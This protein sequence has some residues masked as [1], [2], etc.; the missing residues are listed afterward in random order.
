MPAVANQ[1]RILVAG[2]GNIFLGD[3]AFG[4]EVVR[5]LLEEPLPNGVEAVDFGIRG[6]DL[7]CAI[8]NG[9]D[10][11]VLVDA[12][13][14]GKPPGTLC[15]LEPDL[16]ALAAD[17]TDPVVEGHSLTP[18]SVLRWVKAL[19]GPLPHLRIVGC[20]PASIGSLDAPQDALSLPV[21]AAV[22]PAVRLIRSLV[23]EIAAECLAC[24][25]GADG[26]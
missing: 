26:R 22:N 21:A 24:P 13:P 8:L 15:I 7:S 20:E 23:E 4:V 1:P 2:I 14:R 19:G 18:A 5:Q 3:D 17:Q 10:A 6:F 25:R 12:T 9:Y 11:V 16:E